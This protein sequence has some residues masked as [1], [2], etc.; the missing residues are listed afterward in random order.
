MNHELLELE[1][2]FAAACVVIMFCVFEIIYINIK[3]WALDSRLL[4]LE[5]IASLQSK[6][7][8]ALLELEDIENDKHH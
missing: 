8:K 2:L 6:R 3:C 7:G 5:L 1:T 4:K